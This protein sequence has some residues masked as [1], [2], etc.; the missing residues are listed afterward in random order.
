MPAFLLGPQ[1]RISEAINHDTK[2]GI[3]FIMIEMFV[4]PPLVF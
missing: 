3:I 4:L 2:R 1:Q